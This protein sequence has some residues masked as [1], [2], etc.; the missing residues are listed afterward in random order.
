MVP[1]EHFAQGTD[2]ASR[3]NEQLARS[4]LTYAE[5]KSINSGHEMKQGQVGGTEYERSFYI[6]WNKS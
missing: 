1:D 4:G 6:S 5:N 3:K 2:G